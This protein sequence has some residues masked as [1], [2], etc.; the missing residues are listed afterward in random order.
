MCLCR[1]VR[2]LEAKW[3]LRLDVIKDPLVAIMKSPKHV[4]YLEKFH[5]AAAGEYVPGTK[6]GKDL[7]PFDETPLD[8]LKQAIEQT[9]LKMWRFVVLRLISI[10]IIASLLSD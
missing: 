9:P 2:P 10:V 3:N 6:K 1:I 5:T 8:S 4:S 7:M